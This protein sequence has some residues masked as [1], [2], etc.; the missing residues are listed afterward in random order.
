MLRVLAPAQQ[1]AGVPAPLVG[2][3]RIALRP[4][5][6]NLLHWSSWAFALGF[7]L[8]MVAVL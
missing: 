2:F 3:I 6:R 4:D 1:R 8:A 7:E 5:R